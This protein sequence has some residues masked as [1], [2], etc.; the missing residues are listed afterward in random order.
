MRHRSA[1]GC[2]R[3]KLRWLA[4]LSRDEDQARRLLALAAIY[5]GGTLGK[6]DIQPRCWLG[7]RPS[8]FPSTALGIENI[9]TM[10]RWCLVS[11]REQRESSESV[12]IGSQRR[13][14]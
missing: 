11:I 3:A 13:A 8:W 10:Q 12:V 5:D 14:G 1:F 7:Q 4:R 9:P 2:R 6:R